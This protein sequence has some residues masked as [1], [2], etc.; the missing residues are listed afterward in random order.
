MTKL[1]LL[2][3]ITVACT[4]VN[5]K[6]SKFLDLEQKT[7]DED[8]TEISWPV[9][10]NAKVSRDYDERHHGID[11]VAKHGS[12]ILAAHSGYVIY[13]GDE[14]SG[15]GKMIILDSG[16]GW[17]T[18]YAHLD[19]NMVKEKSLIQRG[20]VIGTMGKTGIVTGVHLH[21]ELMHN[22][23]IVDPERYLPLNR[24]ISK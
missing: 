4:S 15:Y 9:P 7:E 16:K 14:Y 13:S 12:P 22:K 6:N 21:F 24:L 17:S 3:S 8:Y 11:L 23:I 19:K 2:S 5:K 20:D 10:S 18:L 1:F